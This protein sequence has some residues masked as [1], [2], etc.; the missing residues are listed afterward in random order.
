HYLGLDVHDAGLYGPF[1]ANMVITVEPGI[2]IPEGSDCDEKW[3][4]IAVRIEDDIWIT[5]KGPVNLS[6]EAPRSSA[7]IEALMSE[8]SV[9]DDFHLPRLD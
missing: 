2:Y 1:E 8:K 9:L 5:E 3:W 7:E 6:A 4:G